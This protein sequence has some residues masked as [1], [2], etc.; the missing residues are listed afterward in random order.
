MKAEIIVIGDE[1]LIGQTLDTNSGWIAA[2]LTEHSIQVNAIRAIADRE[3]DILGALQEASGR[4]ALVLITGGL[5]PTRDDITKQS[6]SRYFGSP[7]VMNESVLCHVQQIFERSGRPMLP[8][9]RKQAEVL[10]AAEVLFN[11]AGTA[12]GMWIEH[13]NTI[14]IVMPGV[15][16]EMKH[17][18]DHQVLPRLLERHPR[19]RATIHAHLLTAGIGESFLAE[20]LKP[21]EIS[22]PSH[23][24]LAYLPSFAQVRL[25]LSAQGK[26]R[27]QL[28]EE[29]AGYVQKMRERIGVHL[30]N[31]DSR[32]LEETVLDELRTRGLLLSVAE[33]CSGGLLSHL[34]TRVPGCSDVF[35]GGVVAYSNEL[36]SKILGVQSETLER[37]GA[38]S[39]ETARE[40]ANGARLALG[41]DYAVAITGVAGPGGGT[42][43]KP[44]GNVW[45]SV[46]SKNSSSAKLFQLGQRREETIQRSSRHGLYMLLKAIREEYPEKLK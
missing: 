9:N 43:E 34:I 45:I 29:L 15:P 5:G 17:L 22:L 16:F 1:I 26:D 6:L 25:R 7:L 19:Q 33:S 4:S 42:D 12:P 44:V 3:E 31:D 32:S 27:G 38:V 18:I 30:V 46:S 13:R 24:R 2:R 39:E 23:M 21:V 8:V 11:E 35:L 10:E 41:S 37:H 20:L 36:K 14:F 40:M 28:E